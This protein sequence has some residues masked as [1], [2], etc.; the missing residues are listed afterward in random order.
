MRIG[1]QISFTSGAALLRQLAWRRAIH[2]R[3]G[4]LG[5]LFIRPEARAAGLGVAV[6]TLMP[7]NNGE[8]TAWIGMRSQHVGTYPDVLHVIPAG[9]CNSKD[10]VSTG[11]FPGQDVPADFLASTIWSEFF[12]E[13]QGID[14]FENFSSHHWRREW[15]VAERPSSSTTPN[16]S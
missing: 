12:E 2:R 14:A 5:Q 13:W 9:M 15:I 16:W 11:S 8:V 7:N 6:T 10:V 3:T 4:D 1:S